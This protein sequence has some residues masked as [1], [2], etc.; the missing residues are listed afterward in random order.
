MLS[1]YSSRLLGFFAAAIL[2]VPL[3]YAVDKVATISSLPMIEP[4][5]SVAPV[6]DPCL[7]LEVMANPTRP[8]WSLGAATTQC[9]VVESDYG[10]F[11]Q[12]MGNGTGLH[13]L[14][15]SLRYG[16]TS[17][18]DLRWGAVSHQ[19]ESGRSTVPVEGMGDQWI[20]ARYRFHEQGRWSP[21]MALDY[22]FKIPTANPAKGF[23]TGFVDHQFL[24]IASRDLG[25]THLDFNTAGT[26]TG[27]AQ[28]HDGAVQFGLALTQPLSKRLCGILE[29]YGGPQPGTPDRYGAA[30]AGG[31]YSIRPGLVL[32]AAYT[33]A[34]TAGLPRR[35][36]LFGI[37]FARRVGWSPISRNF[38]PARLPGR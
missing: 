27:S 30:L 35:Q 24:L 13:A 28:G 29:S 31:L 18:L 10:F 19:W 3:A 4:V 2:V 20:N 11:G 5:R 33:Q 32:D 38:A 21:A 16:I 6:P 7:S 15:L 1:L 12:G 26:L 36:V 14:P 25:H 23:G 37:T 34:Y 22:G 9:G 8:A 17:R